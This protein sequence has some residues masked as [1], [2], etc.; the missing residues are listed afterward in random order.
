MSGRNT[1]SARNSRNCSDFS[2][3][4]GNRSTGSLHSVTVAHS[5]LI[6]PAEL[7][8]RRRRVPA[9]LIYLS[10]NG[11]KPA[12][13]SRRTA[14]LCCRGWCAPLGAVGGGERSWQRQEPRRARAARRRASRGKSR[15]KPA[16]AAAQAAAAAPAK[17]SVADSSAS[18][19]TAKTISR[20]GL[21]ALRQISRPRHGEGHQRDGAGARD[22]LRAA[23]PAG[24]SL[25]A[26]L[27]T[28]SNFR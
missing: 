25:Q 3:S 5:G 13:L 22:P 23:V 26:A 1:T 8:R 10:L 20:L 11:F 15:T 2:N 27:S 28:M 6:K 24:G 21:R 7:Q 4:G 18:A 14:Q 16:H 19:I 12:A 9:A 17:R